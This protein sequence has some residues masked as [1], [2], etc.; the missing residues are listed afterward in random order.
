MLPDLTGKTVSEAAQ[1]VGTDYVLEVRSVVSKDISDN[2]PKGA[3]VLQDPYPAR[4]ERETPQGSVI[5]VRLSGGQDDVVVPDVSGLTVLQAAKK[6]LDAGVHP[7]SSGGRTIKGVR[8]DEN[9]NLVEVIDEQ[10]GGDERDVSQRS[11]TGA[12]FS[13]LEPVAGSEA[14]PGESIFLEYSASP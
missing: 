3:I 9:G 13:N 11:V 12:H 8:V 14:A 10:I 2:Q 7:N 6:L 5:V 1:T 4:G